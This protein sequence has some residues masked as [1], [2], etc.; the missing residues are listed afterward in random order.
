MCPLFLSALAADTD[1]CGCGF[2]TVERIRLLLDLMLNLENTGNLVKWDR[3]QQITPSMRFTCDGM[4]TKWIIGADFLDGED[5]T[6]FP[7]LEIWRNTGT[8]TYIS[9]EPLYVLQHLV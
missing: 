8:N 1:D 4:I 3:R 7:E 6:L 2:M 5:D 9:M